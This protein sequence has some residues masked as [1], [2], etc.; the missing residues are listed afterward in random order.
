M[1]GMLKETMKSEDTVYQFRRQY[2]RENK[3]NVCPT[4]TANMGTGGHNVPLVKT[5]YG[6]RKLTPRECFSFQGFPETFIIPEI[7]NSHLYKQAGNSVSVP[8]IQ[9]VSKKILEVLKSF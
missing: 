9:A 6:F 5:E 3:S 7:A 4:L 2:V 8:V 1:Y